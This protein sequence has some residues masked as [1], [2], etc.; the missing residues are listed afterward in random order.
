MG[1]KATWK[2]MKM[3]SG[4]G[5]GRKIRQLPYTHDTVLVVE[6]GEH[7]QRHIISVNLEETMIE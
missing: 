2:G 4:G 1:E 3:K 5:K 6:S 7:L